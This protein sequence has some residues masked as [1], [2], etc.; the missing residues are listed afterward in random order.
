MLDFIAYKGPF[1]NDV[2]QGVGKAKCDDGTL[3][4]PDRGTCVAGFP[5]YWFAL[6]ARPHSVAPV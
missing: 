2:M 3:G 1:M 6:G 4:T 5:D